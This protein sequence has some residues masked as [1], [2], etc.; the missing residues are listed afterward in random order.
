MSKLAIAVMVG[1]VI[2]GTMLIVLA[3]V[4]SAHPPDVLFLQPSS[5]VHE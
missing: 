3:L 1:I 5:A 4:V 2:S